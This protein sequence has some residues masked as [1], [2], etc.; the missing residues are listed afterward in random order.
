[1][2]DLEV[3]KNYYGFTTNEAKIYMKAVSNKTIAEIRKSFE[4][5]A[6]K[7]FYED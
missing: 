3:I 1:M 4:S 5:N 2:S 6:K 7:C